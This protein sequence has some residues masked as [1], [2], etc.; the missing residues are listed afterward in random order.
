MR[1]TFIAAEAGG[2]SLHLYTAGCPSNAW[3][4]QMSLKDVARGIKDVL[5]TE[6]ILLIVNMILL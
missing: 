4:K 6:S 5:Y 2:I 3:S 1:D